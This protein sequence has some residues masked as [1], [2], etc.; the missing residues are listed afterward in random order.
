MTAINITRG[1]E[2]KEREFTVFQERKGRVTGISQMC[3]QHKTYGKAIKME[4]N[5]V[6][7]ESRWVMPLEGREF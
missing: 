1:Y 3:S 6:R 5:R 7:G 2:V 4:K